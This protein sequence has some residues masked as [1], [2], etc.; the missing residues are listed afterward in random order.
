MTSAD[1]SDPWRGFRGDRWRESID[2]RMFLQANYTPYEGDDSF[3]TGATERTTTLW[4][5][6]TAMFP[7]ERQRGV[8]DVDPHTPASITA[9]APGY[10][11]RDNELIV[12]RVFFIG[13]VGFMLV[14][15]VG[16]HGVHGAH[17]GQG[18]G[19]RKGYGTDE[20]PAGQGHVT[21][22]PAE[23]KVAGR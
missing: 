18:S 19:G 5:R 8:Y 7:Q 21:P 3:L 6:L 14:M 23:D 1:V 10:I 9:H 11:D 17:G 22:A 12:G 16:G 15:H 20:H 2:S 4:A 13:L